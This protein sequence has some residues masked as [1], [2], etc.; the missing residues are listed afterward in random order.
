MTGIHAHNAKTDWNKGRLL[1]RPHKEVPGTPMPPGLH[2]I[3]WNDQTTGLFYVPARYHAGQATPLVVMLHGA[4]GRSRYGI[5]PFRS[6]TDTNEVILFAPDSQRST[7][8]VI[9]GGYGPDVAHIDNALEYI[10]SHY[11]ID[12]SHIA[13]EGFSD[14][15]S[16]ALSLGLTNGDLFSHIIAFSPGFMAPDKKHG[17][18]NIYMSHGTKDSVLPIQRCSQRLVPQLQKSGYTVHY[19]EFDGPHTVPPDIAQEALQWFLA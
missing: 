19:H 17:T 5:S 12:S 16:Y 10:F 2:E 1:A 18:P 15:A 7:W 6:L 14:G 3:D 9:M 11:T 4:G 8:D 13:I